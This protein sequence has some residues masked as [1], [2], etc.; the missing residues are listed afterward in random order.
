ML[1][2]TRLCRLVCRQ[3][4]SWCP[5]YQRCEHQRPRICWYYHHSR[6]NMASH[7][8]WLPS[9]TPL[10]SLVLDSIHHHLPHCPRRIRPQRPIQQ[11]ANASRHFRGR[12]HSL[13]CCQRLRLCHWLDKLRGR[14]HS[15]SARKRQP[16]QDLRLD[17]GRTHHT[18]SFH[19]NA[20]SRH[21]NRHNQQPRLRQRL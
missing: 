7:C 17:M 5:T 14:L 15:L 8:L 19:R 9:C 16:H 2:R 6:S 3:R 1:Q 11:L 13:F 12:Q 4:D 21:R 20:R 10:R 18:S